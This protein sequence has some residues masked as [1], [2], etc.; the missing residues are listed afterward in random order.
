MKTKSN[1]LSKDILS[2]M[3]SLQILGGQVVNPDNPDDINY[4]CKNAKCSQCSCFDPIK[5]TALGC[6]TNVYCTT[7]SCT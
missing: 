3:E 4:Y 5:S 1:V 7:E 2:E 6:D